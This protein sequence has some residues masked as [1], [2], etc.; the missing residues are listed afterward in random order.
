MADTLPDVAIVSTAWT[1]L[2][3][4]TGLAIGTALEIQ[5]KG[6]A[7]VRL[8]ES[9]TQ[10]DPTDTRGPLLTSFSYNYPDA[11]IP[12]GAGEVWAI[13]TEPGR[14]ALLSVQEVL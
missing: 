5:N 7:W 11:F 10:P 6:T 3:N 2:N 8:V 14:T 12:S 1:S 13:V 4:A 9:L